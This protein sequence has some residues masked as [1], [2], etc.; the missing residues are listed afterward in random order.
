VKGEKL[1]KK[2]ENIRLALAQIDVTVGD[3]AGNAEKIALFAREA[4]SKG[5]DIV[6]FPEL[7][8]TGYPPEDLLHKPKFISDNLACLKGL[9]RSI[10]D[11]VAVVGFVDRAAGKIYNAAALLCRGKV[12]GVYHKALLPNY[13]VFDEMRYFTPGSEFPVYG[14]G[15]AAFGVNICEDIWHAKG[16]VGIEAR[17]GARLIVNINASPYHMGKGRE[18]VD[19]SG[20]VLARA[21]A[22]EEELLI[23][24]V[25]VAVAPRKPR[26]V[27]KDAL[28]KSSAIAPC[29][30]AAPLEPTA[31]VYRALVLGLKDYIAKNGFKKVVLGLS[32]GIDS[33]IVAAIAADAV[34]PHNVVGVAMPSE[35]TSSASSQD[36]EALA[37]N[38]GLEFHVIPIQGIVE[39]FLGELKGVFGDRPRDVAEEN[40]QARVRGNIIMALS[41]KFGYLALNTG[42]KSE[43]SCGY[44]TLY[45]D[46]AGGFGVIKDVPKTL[47][48][49]LAR[50]VNTAAGR[51]L[52]P[53]RV[54]TKAPTA[55]L[56]AN[57]K[58]SDS[59]PAYE[60][61]DRALKLYVEEDK[62]L[63]A[64]ARAGISKDVASRVMRLVDV[65]EYKRRQ[66][67]PGIKITP[68]AF[69]RDRRMPITNHYR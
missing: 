27:L 19:A 65:N 69:G 25:P 45:G 39:K 1:K 51:M 13:G 63:E 48:Y 67:P 24:D 59:L 8:L 32:G 20:R 61:L 44:C 15:R 50:L 9:A 49:P 35:F 36:A 55:E 18:R 43:V 30:I 53:E 62:D 12:R 26:V 29:S 60:L 2:I 34:G 57:Q 37:K 31:E 56:R 38:F 66:A 10:G 17:R 14:I 5:A 41:N 22:F 64:M 16:P 3:L 58:D 23:V 7:A 28:A 47:V 42:N 21:K 40:L 52:I 6:V 4:A 11:I 33:S 68:K 46:M 54:F